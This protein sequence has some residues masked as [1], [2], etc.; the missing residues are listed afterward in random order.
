MRSA[1]GRAG[2][3]TED[4]THGCR[5]LRLVHLLVQTRSR[6]VGLGLEVRLLRLLLRRRNEAASVFRV[7]RRSPFRSTRADQSS[8][9]GLLE[10]ASGRVARLSDVALGLVGVGALLRVL[11]RV[12]RLGRAR[13]DDAVVVSPC[14]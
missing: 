2:G 9:L 7:S 14:E 13:A 4:G 6:L 5:A 1:G 10:K 12:L 3:Q 8:P 11:G